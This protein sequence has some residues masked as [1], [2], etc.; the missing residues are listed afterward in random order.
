AASVAEITAAASDEGESGAAGD[1]GEL[2]KLRSL[3]LQ[4]HP[5]VV[6]DLVRGATVDELIASVE[7]ARAAYQRVADRVRAGA[8]TGS[9]A[10]GGGEGSGTN[11][12]AASAATSASGANPHATPPAGPAG[13][14]GNV[15]DPA[16]IPASEKIRRGLEAARKR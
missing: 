2:E 6:P 7:P 12:G 4:A 8:P 3:V 13:G 1:G 16:N 15:I 11:G 5:D 9:Q 14:A 10:A